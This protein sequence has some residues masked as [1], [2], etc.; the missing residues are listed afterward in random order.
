MSNEVERVERAIHLLADFRDTM[1]AFINKT[2]DEIAPFQPREYEVDVELP[3]DLSSVTFGV[4]FKV[5][6]TEIFGL[7][8]TAQM[9]FGVERDFTLD[10]LLINDEDAVHFVVRHVFAGGAQAVWRTDAEISASKFAASVTSPILLNTK[11][12][13]RGL[14]IAVVVVNKTAEPK[15]FR[16]KI[17]GRE[18][19]VP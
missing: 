16:A 9:V 18:R 4:E 7:P 6:D 10:H 3:P 5:P 1:T 12:Q 13:V 8:E 2:I 11:P 17:I 19:I 14:S 15:R